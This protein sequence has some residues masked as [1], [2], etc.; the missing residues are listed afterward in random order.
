LQKSHGRSIMKERNM[1]EKNKG[2]TNPTC[3]LAAPGLGI[4]NARD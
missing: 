2:S 3:F 1:E 4:F